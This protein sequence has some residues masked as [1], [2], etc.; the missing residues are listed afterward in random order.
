[1]VEKSQKSVS[2]SYTLLDTLCDLVETRTSS[3]SGGASA[4]VSRIIDR[5]DQI[6]QRTLPEFSANEWTII[7]LCLEGM[8]HDPATM[9]HGSLCL[10]MGDGMWLDKLDKQYHVDGKR[11]LDNLCKLSYA[12]EVAIIDIAEQL[13]IAMQEKTNQQTLDRLAQLLGAEVIE[14]LGRLPGRSS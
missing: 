6:V 11:L 8:W 3:S 12:E 7:L 10:R 2:C 1:M 5:Y 9:I 4:A 13:I 14:Q